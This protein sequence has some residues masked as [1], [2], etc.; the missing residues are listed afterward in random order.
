MLTQ[1]VVTYP[2]YWRGDATNFNIAESERGVEILEGMR[3]PRKVSGEL[4]K[5]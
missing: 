5:Q 3:E 4:R 2:V 1:H